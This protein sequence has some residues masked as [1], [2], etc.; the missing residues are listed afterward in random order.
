MARKFYIKNLEN[1]YFNPRIFPSYETEI[2]KAKAFKDLGKLKLHL[3]FLIG[4]FNEM[5]SGNV[6][7]WLFNQDPMSFLPADWYVVEYD[8]LSKIETEVKF[9][10]ATYLDRQA[11]LKALVPLYGSAVK[12]LYKKL[13]DKNELNHY[14]IILIIRHKIKSINDILKIPTEIKE[15]LKTVF[16]KRSDCKR[17]TKN[18]TTVLAFKNPQQAMMFKLA[19]AGDAS[20][21][22]LYIKT[23]VEMAEEIQ[24]KI[25]NGV[26]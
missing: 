5:M 26:I 21:A 6:P 22:V 2:K 10:I 19:F 7:E 25:T 11:K 18:D 14:E 16:V 9:T 13:E 24:A 8:P 4:H 20:M 17:I 23:L 15:A 1:K 12:D 3:L